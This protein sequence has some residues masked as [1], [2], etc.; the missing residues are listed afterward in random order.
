[1]FLFG[2]PSK[3]SATQVWQR[4]LTNL[5]IRLDMY[6]FPYFNSACSVYIKLPFYWTVQGTSN[7]P[8][9]HQFG[10]FYIGSTSITAAKRDFNRMAKLKQVLHDSAVHVE[11]AIRYWANKPSDF[12]QFGTIVVKTCSTYEEAWVF[13]HLLISRW[14]APLNFP[15]ITEFLKLK[16]KGWQ[17]QYRKHNKQFPRVPL[18]DRLY[19]RVR[20]RLH[21]LHAPLT[22]YSFQTTSWTVLYRLTSPGR[23]AFETAASLRSGKYHDWELYAFYRLAGHLEEPLRSQARHKMTQAFKF[24]NLTKPTMNSPRTLPFLAYTQFSSQVQ[25]W[26]RD[27]ILQ[28]KE[29]AIPLHIP[30]SKLRESAYPTIRSLLHHHRRVEKTWNLDNP[31][32]LPCCCHW[33]RKHSKVPCTENSDHLAVSLEDLQL[34]PNLKMFQTVNA[35]STYFYSRAPYWEMFTTS[36]HRW[37]RQHG[38]PPFTDVQLRQFFNAI[39][40]LHVRELEHQPRFSFHTIKHLQHWI[41]HSAILHHADHEQAKLTIFCPCLYFRGAWNTWND[42]ALFQPLHIT[43]EEAEQRIIRSMP[44]QLQKK[45]KWGINKKS[46]L[47]YGFVFLKRK[48]QFLKGRTLISYYNRRFA[49]LLQ[50]TARTIDAMVLQLW[51]QTMGQ[52]AVPQIWTRIH[53]FFT[54][55][56]EE[57]RLDNINDDLVGFFNSVP[58]D[59]LL[60]AVH[61]LVQEW[62][63][64]HGDYTLSVDMSQRGNPLQLSFVGKFH[65]AP[66]K[67]KVIQPH[68]ILSIVQSSLHCHIFIALNMVWHQI[69]G[70]GIGSHISP[71][72][73][74]LAVTLIE[75]T[76]QEMYHHTMTQPPFP[77]LAIRYVDNRYI[78]FP[79]DRIQ[80][81]A[82]Q[83]LAQSDFYEHP[84]ELEEV[85]TSELLGFTVD[86]CCRTVSYSLPEPWQIRDHASAGSLRLRLSGLQ[87]R[88][89]LIS[90]YTYPQ[91]DCPAR[92][93]S[94]IELYKAKGF[95]SSACHYAVRKLTKIFGRSAYVC[96]PPSV[97]K[98][99]CL[100]EVM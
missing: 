83:T 43:T 90:R 74:N 8:V 25:R 95:Q 34:P 17:L 94:L 69:R 81:P 40:R 10:R 79:D 73:S 37:T 54:E 85:T 27:H 63:S 3:S 88:C 44:H 55:T 41:H 15:F 96:E 48:K 71:S 20:R 72:L 2:F 12:H 89:H 59:R 98:S 7:Q 91:S 1:M 68:D 75:R 60:S 47:P 53:S 45:Y 51:P 78:L 70:A 67:T 49:R 18:G 87:S 65:K 30:T 26:L 13:E 31:E 4:R 76:W 77:F 50:V 100:K 11:L 35:N 9:Y 6:T 29:I 38:L 24:R 21:T 23:I 80:D 52:L 28:F 56:S 99:F 19:Q 62:Q 39:W 42:K 66:K 36:V 64:K 57:V 92:I 93:S 22:E 82:I 84:V 97:S 33:I 16:A 58:Q 86:S 32:K 14:Q 46:S 61:S 5:G